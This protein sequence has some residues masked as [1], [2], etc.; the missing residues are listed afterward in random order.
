VVF[1]HKGKYYAAV[2]LDFREDQYWQWV[3][4]RKIL[5]SRDG[6]AGRPYDPRDP[7]SF[8]PL[9][10]SR[11]ISSIFSAL[12]G[13]GMV[14]LQEVAGDGQGRGMSMTAP[15]TKTLIREKLDKQGSVYAQ[16]D[17]Y[18]LYRFKTKMY[19]DLM[20]HLVASTAAS[21]EARVKKGLR[22]GPPPAK[23]RE[24]PDQR[25]RPSWY[26]GVIGTAENPKLGKDGKP[27]D[28][29]PNGHTPKLEDHRAGEVGDAEFSDPPASDDVDQ[30][31]NE[32]EAF[33][34]VSGKPG[35]AKKQE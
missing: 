23:E 14:K 6:G 20:F 1:D 29:I 10:T 9:E 15:I 34:P 13:L 31:V 35:P 21:E 28:Q 33:T 18:R 5:A 25:E 3:R 24:I 11:Y 22:E 32:Q 26:G 30:D 16:S 8:R 4:E 2:P 17:A 12:E 19:S 27:K 7:S